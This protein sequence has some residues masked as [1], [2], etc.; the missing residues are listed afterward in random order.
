MSLLRETSITRFAADLRRKPRLATL[1]GFAPGRTPCVGSLYLFIDRLENGPFQSRCAHRV[2]N[3]E[4][5]HGKHLRNL[6]Q[7]KADKEARR[8]AILEQC[9]SITRALKSELLADDEQP[10]PEGLLK[11]LED[12]LFTTAVIPSA[13]RG[14]LGDLSH[15]KL[16]GDGSALVSGACPQ[17][18]PSCRCRKEGIYDCKCP[19]F[20]RDRTADWGW[21]SYREVFY[22]GHTFYQHVVN[23][24][25]HDLP[26]HVLIARASES[27]FTL[28]LKSLD[29]FL[30]GCR[31]H[32]L[33][34]SI[35]AAIQD[36]GHDSHG[37]YEYLLAKKIH[38]VIA[39]NRRQG[40]HPRPSGNAE[41]VNDDGIPVCPAGLAM[42]RHSATPNHRI[43]FN[44]PV[45]RPTH[46]SGKTTWKSYVA[47]CPQKV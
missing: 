15:L 8:K 10:R 1:A 45:K 19:R 20:Y 42:R 33:T 35:Y 4:L 29:R 16:C 32:E 31:E 7:E 40:Q 47:E 13:R 18:N 6:Q 36:A 46:E 21:D 14:L 37:N 34:L 12:A 22:F 26:V 3:A 38:P 44:C 2:L 28:S 17:G 39:L 30:K 5:R 41:R 11:R 43:V 25:G 24:A 27:D 23:S 9:D